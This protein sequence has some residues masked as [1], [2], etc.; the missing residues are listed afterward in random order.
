MPACDSPVVAPTITAKSPVAIQSRGRLLMIPSNLRPSLRR[1]VSHTSELQRHA[2]EQSR[3]H[4][5]PIPLQRA[6]NAHRIAQ[7]PSPT[8]MKHQRA[9]VKGSKR[10]YRT[11]AGEVPRERPVESQ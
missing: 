5:P 11:E 7:S 1:D 10:P 8:T 2:I 4:I 9:R 3:S 6:A